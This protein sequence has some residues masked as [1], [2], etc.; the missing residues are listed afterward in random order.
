MTTI[1]RTINI[2]DDEEFDYLR[3]ISMKNK[4]V[5]DDKKNILFFPITLDQRRNNN[6]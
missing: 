4:G 6:E 2:S 5:E 1:I 3:I